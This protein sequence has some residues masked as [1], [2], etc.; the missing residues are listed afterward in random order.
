[1]VAILSVVTSFFIR[2][3]KIPAYTFTQKLVALPQ[4]IE[5]SNLVWWSAHIAS[6]FLAFYLIARKAETANI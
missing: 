1:V 2:F 3:D 4:N 5:L 6:A